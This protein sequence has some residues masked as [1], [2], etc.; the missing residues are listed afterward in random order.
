MGTDRLYEAD[1]KQIDSIVRVDIARGR[2][3][4]SDVC[5]RY[6]RTFAGVDNKLA[7]AY[8]RLVWDEEMKK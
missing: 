2:G 7:R 8:Y 4:D 3:Y 1:R 5:N 6:P